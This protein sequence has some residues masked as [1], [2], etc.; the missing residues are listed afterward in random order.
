MDALA[1][2]DEDGERDLDALAEADLLAE[3]EVDPDG[4][5]VGDAEG[6]G[7]GL[8]LD[9][10]LKDGEFDATSGSGLVQI[11]ADDVPVFI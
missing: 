5:K 7:D 11:A 6:D 9:D 1:L 3:A 4:L 8:T 10:G 2:A